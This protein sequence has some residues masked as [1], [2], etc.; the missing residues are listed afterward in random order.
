MLAPDAVYSGRGCK[1][2]RGILQSVFP[3]DWSLF[4]PGSDCDQLSLFIMPC[5]RSGDLIVSIIM[6]LLPSNFLW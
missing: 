4:S 1:L 6:N 2:H 3:D 5:H